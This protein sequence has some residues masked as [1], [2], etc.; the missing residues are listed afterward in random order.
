VDRRR[1]AEVMG[2]FVVVF[3]CSV[4]GGRKERAGNKDAAMIINK[5]DAS[6]VLF[7]CFICVVLWPACY[8]M[9]STNGL[10]GVA[11]IV[12]GSI[13]RSIG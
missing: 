6:L 2:S 1:T 12:D 13:N 11:F 10:F 7:R 5:K 4:G 8:C 3:V 9:D